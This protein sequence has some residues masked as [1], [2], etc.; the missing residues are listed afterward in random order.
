M[1]AKSLLLPRLTPLRLPLHLIH[2]DFLPDIADVVSLGGTGKE[3]N[4][5]FAFSVA[6]LGVLLSNCLPLELLKASLKSFIH[7]FSILLELP[8]LKPSALSFSLESLSVLHVILR[9]A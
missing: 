2:E 7:D 6:F 5:S 3:I 1:E 8:Y 9:V 4:L